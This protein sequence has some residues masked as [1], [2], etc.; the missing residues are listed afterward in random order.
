MPLAH[1]NI[2]LFASGNWMELSALHTTIETYSRRSLTFSSDILND[3][4]GIFRAHAKINNKIYHFW[5]IPVKPPRIVEPLDVKNF[6]DGLWWDTVHPSN[7]RQ[8]F[9]SWSWTG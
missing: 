8:G 7:R 2:H 5:G 1:K 9:P 4:L 3:M 6:T